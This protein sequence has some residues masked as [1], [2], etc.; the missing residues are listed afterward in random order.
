MVQFSVPV[1]GINHR[2]PSFQKRLCISCVCHANKIDRARIVCT[3][4]TNG[5]CGCLVS[6]PNLK[7]CD[8]LTIRLTIF[9]NN[10]CRKWSFLWFFI[11]E[12]LDPIEKAVGYLRL[13][14]NIGTLDS[15]TGVI[16]LWDLNLWLSLIVQCF[17]G[18][19]QDF[20]KEFGYWWSPGSYFTLFTNVPVRFDAYA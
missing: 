10:T 6:V 20:C 5:F 11:S 4:L 18:L 13:F 3:I 8:T 9:H 17:Q 7:V 1:D 15:N 14:C 16:N 12:K 2:M 19:Y